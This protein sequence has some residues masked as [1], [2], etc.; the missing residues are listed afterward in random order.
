MEIEMLRDDNE[1]LATQYE[2]ERQL[3]RNAE[4]RLMET[5]DINE[6][7]TRDIRDRAEV[8]E[9]ATRHLELKCKNYTDQ[10][11]IISITNLLSQTCSTAYSLNF[12]IL[13]S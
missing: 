7:A 5:E 3:R 12:F 2:R 10:G 13:C 11:N 9:T 1:Q 6:A 4:Q 8:L